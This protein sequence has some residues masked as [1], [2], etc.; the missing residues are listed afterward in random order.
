MKVERKVAMMAGMTA[1]VMAVEKVAST[2]LMSVC[3]KAVV[4]AESMVVGKVGL[5]VLL[6]VCTRAA[7]M[8][9]L[10]RAAC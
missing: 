6:M 9:A 4:K 5:L 2:D 8:A 1:I 7:M 10:T 3:E